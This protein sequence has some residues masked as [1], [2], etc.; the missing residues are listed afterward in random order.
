MMAVE[1]YRKVGDIVSVYSIVFCLSM[2][3]LIE[4]SILS[5]RFQYFLT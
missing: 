2:N 1:K 4:L 3:L 5:Y